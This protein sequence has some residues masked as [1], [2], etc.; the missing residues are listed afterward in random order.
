MEPPFTRKT[1]NII[2]SR[3]DSEATKK[4]SIDFG[5]K[6]FSIL[7]IGNK[8]LNRVLE[9]FLCKEHADKCPRTCIEC[10]VLL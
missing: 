10:V 8:F 7:C 4:I 5:S 6:V 1:V 3:K 9:V 2:F